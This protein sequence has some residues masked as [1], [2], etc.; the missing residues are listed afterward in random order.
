MTRPFIANIR[1]AVCQE[2]NQHELVASTNACGWPDLDTRPPEM[3]RS[4]IDS[5]VQRCPHCGYC[6]SEI[7]K[8]SAKA[9]VVVKGDKYRSQLESA[10]SPGLANSFL[11]EAMIAR[12]KGRLREAAWATIHAAW[13]CD[14]SGHIDPARTCRMKAIDLISDATSKGVKLSE[15]DGADVA[16]TVDLLRRCGQFD[17]AERLI[18]SRIDSI[19]RDVIAGMLRHQRRLIAERDTLCHTIGQAMGEE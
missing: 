5:W 2:E 8:A 16:I 3:E 15:E 18:E 4:T 6:G 13:A 10:D 9:K 1:C 17:E 11:C 12:R 14:D 19:S 7:A